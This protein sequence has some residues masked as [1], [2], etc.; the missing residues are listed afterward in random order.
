[1]LSMPTQ[2]DMYQEMSALSSRMVEAA[3]DND[4]DRLV[5]L[6][7]SVKILPAGILMGFTVMS[8]IL[9]DDWRI[10]IALLFVIGM[11]AG[12]RIVPYG[13]A[14]MLLTAGQTLVSAAIMGVVILALVDKLH[15]VLLIVIGAIVYAVIIFLVRGLTISEMKYFVGG[16]FRKDGKGESV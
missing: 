5:T 10:A 6:E 14:R 16:M 15:F 7:K 12:A 8:M 9:V 3:Q 11:I 1:M 2:I 13:K 4:W